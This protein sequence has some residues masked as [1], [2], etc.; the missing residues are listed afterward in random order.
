MVY[1]P[2]TY[3]TIADA[4]ELLGYTMPSSVNAAWLDGSIPDDL[5]TKALTDASYY[6]D[7]LPWVG[8]KEEVNQSYAFPRVGLPGQYDGDRRDE[9]IGSSVEVVNGKLPYPVGVA[10]ALTA[11]HFASQYLN[12]ATDEDELLSM[13]LKVIEVGSMKVEVMAQSEAK[14]KI[15]NAAMIYLAAYLRN[16]PNGRGLREVRFI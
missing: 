15:P 5:K 4:N 8:F 7:S 9:L 11:A 6:F 16:S 3:I 12:Q 2:H 14:A 1:T 10:L 13:G